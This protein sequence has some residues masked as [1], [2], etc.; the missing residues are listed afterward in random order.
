MTARFRY[1]HVV[2]VLCL[3]STVQAVADVPV[4]QTAGNAISSGTRANHGAGDDHN[5]LLS[6]PEAYKTG[7]EFV[8]D[9]DAFSLLRR[10]SDYTGGFMLSLSGR[11]AV[12]YP[13]SVDP[14][15][16]RLDQWTG[17]NR[18]KDIPGSRQTHNILFGLAAYTP[19]NIH[20]ATPIYNDRP[21][22]SVLFMANSQQ[23][24]IPEREVAHQTTLTLGVLGLTVAKDLQD[25]IHSVLGQEGASGWDNQISS[26]G[27]PTARYTVSAQ[28]AYMASYRNPD[29]GIDVV[30]TFDA[31]IGYLTDVGAG[32]AFRVGRI[33]TTWWSFNR[34]QPDYLNM[35][36][37]VLRSGSKPRDEFFVW[38]GVDAR[39]QLYNALLQGQF[40][41]SE[42][43]FPWDQQNHVLLSGWLGVNRQF[44]N[45]YHAAFVIRASTPALETAT[46]HTDVWGS[47]IVGRSF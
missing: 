36:S 34:S 27:E 47:M 10:D 28:H 37:P 6:E 30:R 38:G 26:G 20:L 33:R 14:W 3:G 22:A 43:T 35:V 13:F 23:T 41:H 45:G 5:G 1:L 21:Y 24:V 12:E 11:R 16:S 42:V 19:K 2:F 39:L 46:E 15:L 8:L 4:V 44:R 9:N 17:L 29:R 31:S 18:L 40:R 25:F 32:L 7:W